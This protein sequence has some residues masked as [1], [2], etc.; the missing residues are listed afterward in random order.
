VSVAAL[1]REFRELPIGLIDEPVL[2]AR[3]A[4]DE[5]ALDEL[6]ADIRLKGV[7]QP[8]IVAKTGDRYEV[9]AGHRRRVAAG[10]AGLAAVPCIVYPSKDAALEGVKYSENRFRE[11]LGPADEAILFSELLE[12]DC[13]GDVD[14]LCVQLGEKRSYVENRLSLFAGDPQVFEALQAHKINIGVAHQLNK[15]TDEL[16]RRSLLYSAIHGGATV[17]VVAGWILDWRKVHDVTPPSAGPAAGG[18]A[19]APIPDSD[20]FKCEICGKNHHPHLLKYVPVHDYCKLAILD[21]LL[22][23]Y[24]GG[25]PLDG[26]GN[27]PRRG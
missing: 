12:R 11:E 1:Q 8:L 21:P 13:G 22:D 17:S 27:D 9:I 2:A 23:T 5:T 25:D 18:P 16:H 14:R 4:M 6:A 19:P 10:R 15:C 24:R 3:S 26:T 7:L 20:P